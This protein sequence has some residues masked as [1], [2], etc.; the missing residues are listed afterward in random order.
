[1]YKC[2]RSLRGD[3]HMKRLDIV[4]RNELQGAGWRGHERIKGEHY[5]ANC[6]AIRNRG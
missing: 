4:Y 3:N 1:M 5:E 2:S 6:M